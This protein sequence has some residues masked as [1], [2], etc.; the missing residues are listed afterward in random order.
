MSNKGPLPI[1]SPKKRKGINAES[2]KA[3]DGNSLIQEIMS[4]EDF[5]NSLTESEECTPSDEDLSRVSD[6]QFLKLYRAIFLT[7]LSFLVGRRN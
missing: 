3:I 6:W 2:K 7:F 5:G 4:L 1:A